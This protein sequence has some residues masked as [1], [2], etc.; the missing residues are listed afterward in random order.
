MLEIG[1]PRAVMSVDFRKLP[2]RL[3][4]LL[5]VSSSSS[6][7]LLVLFIYYH[8][9]YYTINDARSFAFCIFKRYGASV[10]TR[11]QTSIY[12]C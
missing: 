12:I 5:L 1:Y 11:Q 10:N 9:Y 3:V 6:S 7:C 4:G 8:Y 2:V